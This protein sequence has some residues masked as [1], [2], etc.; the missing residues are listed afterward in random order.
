[1]RVVRTLLTLWIAV[2]LQSMLAPAIAIAGIRPDFP[3]LIVLLVALRHGPAAGAIAGFV[4]GLFVDLNSSHA[5]GAT[6]L[7]NSLLAFAVGSVADRIVGNSALAR[8]VVVFVA[9]AAR[10]FALAV[11]LAPGGL[12]GAARSLA[13]FAVPG[14]VYTAILSPFV[15]AGAERMLGRWRE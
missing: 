14:A 11:L 2:M 6:S 15:L 9:A 10:D 8:A 4:A 3:I 5:L 13:L 1:V 12:G 7:A